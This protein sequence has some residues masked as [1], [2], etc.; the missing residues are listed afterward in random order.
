MSRLLPPGQQQAV[1]VG[2]RVGVRVHVQPDGAA[3][4]QQRRR[5]HS[6]LQH[7]LP[8]AVLAA[9]AVPR[10]AGKQH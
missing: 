3:A 1:E 7:L 6:Q 2:V 4:Q 10:V 9:A 8:G 5:A